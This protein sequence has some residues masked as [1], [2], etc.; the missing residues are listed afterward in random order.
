ME[1]ARQSA[2][3]AR[4]QADVD[5]IFSWHR[6]AIAP[7]SEVSEADKPRKPVR[8]NRPRRLITLGGLAAAVTAVLLIRPALA[9]KDDPAFATWTAAPGWTLVGS[10]R[11]S[12]LADCHRAIRQVGGGMYSPDLATAESAIAGRHRA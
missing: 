2:D 8:R 1:P 4:I 6:V 10:G 7:V 9:G 5:R 3:P 11:D 12:A